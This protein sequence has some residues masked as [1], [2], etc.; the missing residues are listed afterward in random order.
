MSEKGFNLLVRN[1]FQSCM[2]LQTLAL[3]VPFYG[4]LMDFE[5]TALGHLVPKSKGSLKSPSLECIG[6][7]GS[8]EHLKRIYNLG[9]PL[10]TVKIVR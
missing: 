10:E 6:L 9:C 3:E 5:I 2:D 4:E 7:R 8:F 1:A